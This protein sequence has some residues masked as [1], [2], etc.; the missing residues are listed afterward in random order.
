ML[1]K[2]KAIVVVIIKAIY[3][4]PVLSPACRLLSSHVVIL[5]FSPPPALLELFVCQELC[6]VDAPPVERE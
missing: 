4:K 2:A 1:L 6:V 3:P 5:F